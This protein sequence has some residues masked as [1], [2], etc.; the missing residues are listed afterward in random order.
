MARAE[1]VFWSTMLSLAWGSASAADGTVTSSVYDKISN[2]CFYIIF[3][4]DDVLELGDLASG[5]YYTYDAYQMG[6]RPE[7]WHAGCEDDDFALV[8]IDD[9]HCA[10]AVAAAPLPQCGSS[11]VQSGRYC[12]LNSAGAC[13]T[14]AED[15]E[16]NCGLNE[17]AIYQA[18]PQD[19]QRYFTLP[20]ARI[21]QALCI[22]SAVAMLIS[23]GC[24]SCFHCFYMIATESLDEKSPPLFWTA[25]CVL[26]LI[27]CIAFVIIFMV[28]RGDEEV[29]L[30]ALA[31]C[32]AGA[33]AS[34]LLLTCI[35]L[36]IAPDNVTA[37]KWIGRSALMQFPVVSFLAALVTEAEVAKELHQKRQWYKFWLRIGQ[38]IPDLIIAAIDM[39]LFDFGPANLLDLSVSIVELLVY[40]LPKVFRGLAEAMHILSKAMNT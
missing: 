4:I 17:L 20:C 33:Y 11:D 15:L 39:A 2:P 28:V 29:S 36:F 12:S 23:I 32:I 31:S 25:A 40:L 18:V 7:S 38:D 30:I 34:G 21:K 6:Y 14:D 19:C 26:L 35:L 24:S 37:S 5:A 13:G 10:D 27:G 8:A 3:I 1:R 22:A 16:V 9:S